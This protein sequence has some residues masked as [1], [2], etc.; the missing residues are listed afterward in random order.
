MGRQGEGAPAPV[1]KAERP[2]AAALGRAAAESYA[3]QLMD[4]LDCQLK[5]TSWYT[6]C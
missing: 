5:Q 2:K 3:A 4:K 1:C 6:R